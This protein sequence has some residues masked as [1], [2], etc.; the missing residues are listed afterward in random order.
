MAQHHT[1]RTSHQGYD[2]PEHFWLERHNAG[3]IAAW[4]IGLLVA[5]SAIGLM[6][7]RLHP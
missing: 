3:L 6:A 5:L 1:H 4:A 2:G 7:A